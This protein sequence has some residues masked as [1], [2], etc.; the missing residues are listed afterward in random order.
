MSLLV[1]DFDNI[2][3]YISGQ[4]FHENYCWNLSKQSSVRH[5]SELMIEICRNKKVL[6][7]GCCDHLPRLANI[8][9]ENT[10]LHGLITHA[11]SSTIGVDIDKN[12]IKYAS[13]L[14][15]LNNM[16]YGDMASPYRI[17]AI[18]NSKFD[19]VVLGEMLMVLND[20]SAF[21]HNIHVLYGKNFGKLVITVPN[22]F[23]GGNIKNVFFN[24]ESV[25][26]ESRCF[27]TPFTLSKTAFDG[28]FLPSRIE[29][30]TY[31]KASRA[32][33]LLL[34]KFP[35]LSEVIVYTGVPKTL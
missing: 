22:A 29:M 11:S 1:E 7:I 16:I 31:T 23:R 3:P 5:R 15:Q 17:P 8:I 19:V 13:E 4:K 21:L 14:S 24:K 12:A 34:G 20:P 9:A 35:L 25:Y 6:H 2:L 32:K 10:W 26:T 28:G 27:F 30:A 18:E 33:T